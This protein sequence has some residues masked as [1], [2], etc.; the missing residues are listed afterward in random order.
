[1][2]ALPFNS[3]HRNKKALPTVAPFR[4]LNFSSIPVAT[5]IEVKREIMMYSRDA[6][7]PESERE[8]HFNAGL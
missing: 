8:A 4:F 5:G 7:S 3:G 2:Q 1:M 6:K